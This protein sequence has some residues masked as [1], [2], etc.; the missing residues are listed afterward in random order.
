M[1]KKSIIILSAFLLIGLM[2]ATAQNSK[3]GHIN[4][5]DLLELMPEKEKAAKEVQAF[6][7]QLE[8]QLKTM[9]AEYETKLREY[10]SQQALMTEPVRQLKVQEITDLENRIGQ[11]QQ[12][13]QESLAQKENEILKPIIDKAKK[14]IDEVAKEKGYDYIL[15]TGLGMVLYANDSEDILPLVKKKLGLQ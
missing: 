7:Q 12:T 14:A 13:A 10:Q 5:N 15:D 11:F 2:S 1:M 6:A 9:S 4:S 8:A 3:V